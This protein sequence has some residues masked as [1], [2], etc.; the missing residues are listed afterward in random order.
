MVVDVV[1]EL[2]RESE[3]NE[4]LY[5]DDLVLMSETIEGLRNKLL[6]WKEALESTGLKV[7]IGNTN[8]VVCGGITKGSMSKSMVDPCGVCSL[9]VKANLLL[10][11]QFGKWI[12]SRCTRVKRVTPKC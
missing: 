4:L 12:H 2:A 10:C 9:R 5:A 8:L 11:V 6:K 3:L 7:N 1:T